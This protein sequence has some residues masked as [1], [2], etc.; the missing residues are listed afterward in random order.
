[1][2]K[3]IICMQSTIR[4]TLNENNKYDVEY[5]T[6]IVPENGL[7]FTVGDILEDQEFEDIP[8]QEI[9]TETQKQALSMLREHPNI[10]GQRI[11]KLPDVESKEDIEFLIAVLK[12]KLIESEL[13]SQRRR[14]RQ[15]P[16]DTQR[17]ELIPEEA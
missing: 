17:I 14:S 11:K 4:T 1:M 7:G 13:L 8:S 12:G 9:I 2:S 10:A 6:R 15:T 5:T 16:D 3:K